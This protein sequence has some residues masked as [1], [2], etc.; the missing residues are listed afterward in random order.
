[1][2]PITTGTFLFIAN[3]KKR[4]IVCSRSPPCDFRH[5][6]KTAVYIQCSAF[7][8]NTVFVASLWLGGVTQITLK[9]HLSSVCLFED[10]NP[11]SCV[12]PWR[13]TLTFVYAREKHTNTTWGTCAS[14]TAVIKCSFFVWRRELLFKSEN[15]QA[16]TLFWSS[17]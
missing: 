9:V 5:P 12:F 3:T 1:M 16:T 15:K 14:I 17:E 6:V 11:R 8:I 10:V 7:Y 13:A 2:A 4:V